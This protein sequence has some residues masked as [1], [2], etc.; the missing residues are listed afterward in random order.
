MGRPGLEGLVLLRV[1]VHIERTEYF[2][3]YSAEE[4]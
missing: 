2:S 1:G 3:E 4:F